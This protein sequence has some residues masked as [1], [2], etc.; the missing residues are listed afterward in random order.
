MTR[1]KEMGG[2]L[3]GKVNW[4]TIDQLNELGI[5][6]L[7]LSY[8]NPSDEE[9]EDI[10]ELCMRFMSKKGFIFFTDTGYRAKYNTKHRLIEFGVQ[11]HHIGNE[12]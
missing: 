7:K 2:G 1:D 6:S 12:L 9:L 5:T 4:F 3:K 10:K 11:Y 8:I